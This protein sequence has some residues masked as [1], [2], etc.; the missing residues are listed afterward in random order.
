MK[1]ANEGEVRMYYPCL[2]WKQGEQQALSNLSPD[3]KNHITPIIEFPILGK[4]RLKKETTL[5]EALNKQ[6]SSMIKKIN[7]FPQKLLSCWGKREILLDINS[8]LN[9]KQIHITLNEIKPL[10]YNKSISITPIITSEF[11]S[12]ELINY[13]KELLSLSI[14]NTVAVRVSLE[15][16]SQTIS[17]I[18]FILKELNLNINNTTIIFDLK[19]VSNSTCTQCKKDFTTLYNQFNDNFYK[20][21]LLSGALTLP[22]KFPS[23]SNEYLFRKDWVT[24]C[25]LR[26]KD[27]YNI[28][29]G[30]YTTDSARFVDIPFSGAPKIKYTLTDKWIV[31]KGVKV[32][33]ESEKNVI[34]YQKMSKALIQS[35]DWRN[36]HRSYGEE[37]ILNCALKKVEIGS[38]TKWVGISINQHIAFVVSQMY[39]NQLFP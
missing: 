16:A 38:S 17:K 18:K 9:Q 31:Y 26:N 23:N 39:A 32:R 15:T 29:F 4:P 27:N 10:F 6:Y 37:Q 3:F 35:N 28:E 24:W 33:Q 2:R 36:T 34:Q 1:V 8:L 7:D 19:D 14:I 21:I 11:S 5:E 22:D 25:E 20:K 13:L 12:N 30:D